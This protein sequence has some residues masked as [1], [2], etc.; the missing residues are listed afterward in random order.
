[1]S[2]RLLPALIAG[3]AVLVSACAG[4]SDNG[5]TG[6]GDSA[7]ENAATTESGP[8]YTQFADFP[9]QTL[10]TTEY[11]APLGIQVKAIDAEWLPELAGESANAGAHYLAVYLAVTGELADRGVQG[12]RL[13]FL[14]AKFKIEQGACDEYAT[15]SP[16]FCYVKARPV[17]EPERDIAD[18][19]W[20]THTWYAANII[21]IR[22]DIE[23]G[24]T[25]IGVVGFE[26]PDDANLVGNVELC[27]PTKEH[28]YGSSTFPCVPIPEP[29]GARS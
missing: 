5:S 12:A 14:E 2:T 17:A 16:D 6:T 19:T 27:G 26:I 24:E 4:D 29:E 11:G 25:L 21:S 23:A 13:D 7:A 15:E 10:V 22:T 9:G 28:W 18:N 1:M 20:R 8:T 3:L